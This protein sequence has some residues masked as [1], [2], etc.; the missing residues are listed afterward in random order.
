METTG[1]T[2]GIAVLAVLPGQGTE[3]RSWVP[4]A[5]TWDPLHAS[6]PIPQ[7]GALPV[8]ALRS[9]SPRRA[10]IL[11][12]CLQHCCCSL[13]P[14]AKAGE[15]CPGS[16]LQPAGLFPWQKVFRSSAAPSTELWGRDSAHPLGYHVKSSPQP[17]PPGA[18]WGD[19]VKPSRTASGL[20]AVLPAPDI[21]ATSRR[22]RSTCGVVLQP[23]WRVL[24]EL[25][26][27]NRG[28]TGCAEGQ[29]IGC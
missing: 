14:A 22:E 29:G 27:L 11:C 17:A 4:I 19:E 1:Q 23:T 7:M 8:A 2:Q 28:G 26:G 10:P 25:V 9:T 13:S 16:S 5:S 12:R 24:A 18:G 3:R 21:A 6:T 20:V 15:T